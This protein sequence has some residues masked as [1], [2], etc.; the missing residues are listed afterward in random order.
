MGVND[1]SHKLSV[2][3]SRS[4]VG[5]LV[6]SAFQLLVFLLQILR[7][8]FKVSLII[9]E[10][11]AAGAPCQLAVYIA[12]LSKSVHRSCGL[13]GLP[14]GIASTPGAPQ[15]LLVH[16]SSKHRVW[17]RDLASVCYI[18]DGGSVCGTLPVFL[19]VSCWGPRL[20]TVFIIVKTVLLPGILQSLYVVCDVM[21]FL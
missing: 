12:A 2:Q 18:C 7:L 16:T 21:R 4:H 14:S 9:P 3:Y 10:T 6:A 19:Y 5:Q 15:F 17:G 13:R 20:A 8:C 11:W 1:I